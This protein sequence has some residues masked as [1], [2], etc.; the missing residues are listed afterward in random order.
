M[1]YD[2][3]L[4]FYSKLPLETRRAIAEMIVVF[5]EKEQSN[6]EAFRYVMN[7]Y[8]NALERQE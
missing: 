2:E 6:E 3:C 5:K 7:K 4:I 8:R 1:N